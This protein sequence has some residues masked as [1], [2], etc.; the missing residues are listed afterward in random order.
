[1][2]WTPETTTRSRVV[3][4]DL[5]GGQYDAALDGEPLVLDWSGEQGEGAFGTAGYQQVS[6]E[7]GIDQTSTSDDI[8][9]NKLSANEF[10]RSMR[11]W[12]GGFGQRRYDVPKVS[13]ANAYRESYNADPRVPGELSLQRTVTTASPAT[14]EIN[15]TTG[16][17]SHQTADGFWFISRANIGAGTNQAVTHYDFTTFTTKTRTGDSFRDIAVAPNSTC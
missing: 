6:S 10:W 7:I 14:F 8:S 3:T 17:A 16:S 5:V 12:Q 9:E 2:A 13:A 15:T 11:D 4:V 1:V